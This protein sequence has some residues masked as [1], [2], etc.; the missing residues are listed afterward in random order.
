MIPVQ[1]FHQPSF[2]LRVFLTALLMTG[3]MIASNHCA[4][5][6][7]QPP[8]QSA[9]THASC[10]GRTSLPV[11]TPPASGGERECCK[12]LHGLPADTA[13]VAAKYDTALFVLLTFA[14]PAVPPVVMAQ[15]VAARDNGP[16]RALSFA[17][18][19]LQRSVLSH[20]PPCFV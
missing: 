10:C 6:L 2:R 18:R 19:I 11:K 8:L 5:G 20:A 1:P 3:W 13:K 14:R 4:F 7:M 9:A 12:A 16:P 15:A 17:E